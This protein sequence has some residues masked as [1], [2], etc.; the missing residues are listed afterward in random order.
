MLYAMVETKNHIVIEIVESDVAPT[1]PPLPD[2]TLIGAV[3]CDET[4]ARG[5]RYDEETQSFTSENPFA[6]RENTVSETELAIL[7]TQANTEY[8]VCLAELRGM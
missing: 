4:V 7:E 2:G 3:E 8:L 6:I 5:W 1:F